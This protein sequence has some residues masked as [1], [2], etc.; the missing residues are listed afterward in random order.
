MKIRSFV[1]KTVC[2]AL[3]LSNLNL[4]GYVLA[5]EPDAEDSKTAETAVLP[6][7]EIP[8]EE[9]T[10]VS[11]EEE[12]ESEEE[13]AAPADPETQE[14]TE[15]AEEE[16]ITPK[17]PEQEPAEETAVPEEENTEPEEVS[18]EEVLTDETEE[19]PAGD[20]IQPEEEYFEEE[21]VEL[22]LEAGSV[23][24]LFQYSVNGE[25]VKI[26][27]YIGT[28]T[29]VVIPDTIE[30]IL[31]TVI[32]G[33]AF[34]NCT[35]LTE[36]DLPEGL[37]RIEDYAFQGCTGLTEIEIPD[38][39]T[40]IG[41]YAFNNCRNISSFT[42]P[43]SLNETGTCIFQNMESLKEITVPEGV[44][45]LPASVFNNAAYLTKV[46]LPS[47]LSVIGGSAFNNCT[48]LTEIDLPEGLTKIEDYAFQGCTGLTEIEIP[49]SVTMIGK[50]AFQNCVG[51]K[52]VLTS[53]SLAT[54]GQN[55]FSGC[56]ALEFFH[57]PVSL[58]SAGSGIFN[59]AS[60]LKI[61]NVTEGVTA[62]PNNVFNGANKIKRVNLPDTLQTVGEYAFNSSSLEKLILPDTVTKIGRNAFA[63]M[64]GLTDIWIGRNVTSFGNYLFSGCDL[65]RLTIH[66]VSGSQAQT[67]ASDNNIAFS[68][69]P[70]VFDEKRLFGTITDE[71]SGG[72]AGI[73][74]NI[75]NVSQNKN[76][77]E[78]VTDEQGIWSYELAEA[79]EE[80]IISA[81]DTHY[82]ITPS[83]IRITVSEA[84]ETDAGTMTA[85]LRDTE[86][87]PGSLFTYTKISGSAITITGFNG[88]ETE[89][90]IPEKIDGYRVLTIGNAAFAGNTSVTS[91]FMP[92]TV[93]KT[94]SKAFQ[95]CT[96]LKKIRISGSLKE[97]GSYAFDGC[98]SLEEITLPQGLTSIG[99][100]ALRGCSSLSEFV[101]PFSLSS[102]GAGILNG[103]VGVMEVTVPEGVKALPANVF[104]ASE[105]KAVNLPS[106]LTSIGN[107]AFRDSLL[108]E[109]AALPESITSFGTSVFRGCASLTEINYPS[110]LVTAGSGCFT[111]TGITEITVPEG[112]VSLPDNIFR[113][114]GNLEKV[115]LPT[116]LERIGNYTFANCGKLSE[117]DI[118]ESVAA[119]GNNALQNC[120]SI[121]KLVL[122][123]GL[124]SIG[125]YAFGSCTS[126]R[127]INYPSSLNTA[128][129]GIFQNDS[130]LI[131][132]S[133][134][135]GVTD[136][137]GNVFSS[138]SGLYFFE[139]PS[140]LQSI[141]AD[142]FLEASQI[143]KLVLPDHVSQIMDNAF[144]KCT[145]L[146][147][148]WIGPEVTQISAS[149]FDSVST[150]QLVIHGVSGSEAERFANE[151][152]YAFSTEY[153]SALP[154][155]LTGSVTDGEGGPMPEVTL[156]LYSQ[157]TKKLIGEVV[158]DEEGNWTY[159][160][161]KPGAGYVI[162]AAKSEIYAEPL[163]AEFTAADE[164]NTAAPGI[165]GVKITPV[166]EPGYKAFGWASV[167]NVETDDPVYEYLKTAEFNEDGITVFAGMRYKK[168]SDTTFKKMKPIKWKVLSDNSDGTYTMIS[169][170]TMA[171]CDFGADNWVNSSVRRYLNGEFMTNSFLEEE[172]A[173]IKKRNLSSLVVG[174]TGL[175][176]STVLSSDQVYVLS[177]SEYSS[178]KYG[179]A[180]PL[181]NDLKRAA[182][183]T[184]YETGS[185][186]TP[187]YGDVSEDKTRWF[188]WTRDVPLQAYGFALPA[189]VTCDGELAS[190]Y[191]VYYTW[192]LALRPVINVYK[193]SEYLSDITDYIEGDIT[194]YEGSFSYRADKNRDKQANCSYTDDY[195]RNSS[196]IYN[197]E[198]ARMSV[199][200]A[201]S[202]FDSNEGV[203]MDATDSYYNSKHGMQTTVYDDETKL[204]SISKAKNVYDLLTRCGFED[205][206]VNADYL[207]DTDYNGEQNDGNNIGVCFGH[208]EIDGY[209]LLAI[210][211][212]GAGYGC[213]W[214]G[215]FN[216]YE[217]GTHHRGFEIARNTVV[218]ALND[219][220]NMYGISGNVKCW[221]TG[222]S[223]A[224]ATANLTA[225]YIADNGI[226]NCT[227]AP[228]NIFAYTFETP[229][230][231]KAG[232]TS[233]SNYNG[234]WNIVN[235]VDFVPKVA[236]ENWGYKRYG[237]DRYLPS[238]YTYYNIFQAYEGEVVQSLNTLLEQQYEHIPQTDNQNILLDKL[239][240]GVADLAGNDATSRTYTVQYDLQA[241]WRSKAIEADAI[242]VII[243]ELCGLGW[244]VPVA[245]LNLDTLKNIA[246]AH[247]PELAF[248]WLQAI[249]PDD[250][251]G[252]GYIRYDILNCPV[253]VEVYDQNG[254]R[255]LRIIDDVVYYEDGAYLEAFIDESGQKIISVPGDVSISLRILGTDSGTLNYT[256]QEYDISQD[257]VV[258]VRNY[259]DLP[260]QEGTVYSATLSGVEQKE[261]LI[262][263]EDTLLEVSEEL[264]AEELER[265]SVT[266]HAEGRGSVSPD[267][268]RLKGEFISITAEPA[269]GAEFT[270]WYN[271]AGDL[272]SEEAQYRFR[273][274]RS[275][276]L[277]ARFYSEQTEVT[278]D[279]EEAAV[280]LNGTLQLHAVM[281]PEGAAL[282]WSS[283]D[284]GIASVD[285]QGLVRG[286]V[287]GTVIISVETDD[288]GYAE[289]K[290]RVQFTDVTDPSQFYYEYI[291]DMVDKGITTGYADG[292]FR[293]TADCNRAAVVTFL[294]R[295]SGKP[296]PSKMATFKDMTG[297]SDFDKAISW[298]AES[299][300]T[301]GWDDNTFRPWNTCNR[302]AV[303]TFLWRAAGKPAPNK[304]AEFTDMTG[305]SDF[306]KAISW[307]SENG[308]TTG[309]ADNTFRP[310][311]TCNRLAIASFLG[312]YNALQSEQ[313]Q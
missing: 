190:G 69:E 1:K 228:A 50:Y 101:Y 130:S 39:V 221:L 17:I 131:S 156:E 288:G 102:A 13:E 132:I 260:L 169:A 278:L 165:Q 125:Q 222:Y 171:V 106:T 177:G 70:V 158:T 79:G 251:D 254:V 145:D 109:E 81:S 163:N 95:N 144:K 113:E 191:H 170:T 255:Q 312:R 143:E 264:N 269:G 245:L 310:W 185:V 179:F 196:W 9:L 271:A 285:D 24:E 242:A 48:G 241:I 78:P 248:S 186:T 192:V 218:H 54:I 141:G 281:E 8:E 23:E 293:P 217:S 195:F 300:I 146:K 207:I 157:S 229:R 208:K 268:S 279:P 239:I 154:S 194:E 297:N 31:V 187:A 250:M 72:V 287:P 174:D 230:N 236:F 139:L 302:A 80:Y 75:F 155:R 120:S 290:I 110:S 12:T 129:Y 32:G 112:V 126:L 164:G 304:M 265:F 286:L 123:E 55:V 7:P 305:T 28:E 118:P 2:I 74:V 267:A 201:M 77:A 85:V 116:T 176:T 94:E 16:E 226:T 219:Y 216:V 240:N 298:A 117:L 167:G 231:T 45:T 36:I 137:P 184:D 10:G 160:F 172:R 209:T 128:G 291:Y 210:V 92:D 277:T 148:I 33:S 150:S 93:T 41:K 3:V 20:E 60:S 51:L 15:A 34:N 121:Q 142:A 5:E 140:T 138:A 30:G 253:D 168:V 249:G 100:Y 52:K 263:S 252:Y 99:E 22:V 235:P 82:L 62:L 37:T 73:A 301:T 68:T 44:T 220:V 49:A 18:A 296:E 104:R 153:F 257:K 21:T 53:D 135:E 107:D 180:G 307:A 308:I 306:D 193:D 89:I 181:A 262:Y 206:A 272:V 11:A 42:Y 56:S 25:T 204:L 183:H 212:R 4:S 258:N 64:T 173:D 105:I 313:S 243:S 151:K 224:A 202:G 114:A 57:Y 247:Y 199:S 84:D 292:T 237:R 166:S 108:L 270:G 98:S 63:N 299:G 261:Y 188:S 6:S 289:C 205:I 19:Q 38:S 115:W 227:V 295:L 27:K 233:G 284:P 266:L 67:Y 136:L 83:F 223:R 200:L 303:M 197:H 124:Q 133:V 58:S 244:L 246:F 43:R 127:E 275:V 147:D 309:W 91:I 96:S 282:T 14:V 213:E 283:S 280:S 215:N 47:T 234:I 122:P 214:I 161:G 238:K 35:G 311:N 211:V 61:I 97:L 26:T 134:P 71:N 274:D 119:I 46:D 59:G 90:V 88:S 225:A 175:Y 178:K 65:S 198:L 87:T 203:F 189:Y 76:E 232:N 152:G 294:W 149:A 103:A 40:I 66:G 259:Y 86:D 29:T 162:S 273:V 111:D 159:E 182:T 256:V 276:D